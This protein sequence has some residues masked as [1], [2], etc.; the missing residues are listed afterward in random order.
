MSTKKWG[1]K[2]QCPLGYL[3]GE[4]FMANC[5]LHAVEHL[6]GTKLKEKLI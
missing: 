6:E 5:L 3:V 1:P 4:K 2:L